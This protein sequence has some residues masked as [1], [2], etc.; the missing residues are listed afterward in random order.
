MG[1]R[2]KSVSA[3]QHGRPYVESRRPP[4][5][6]DYLPKTPMPPAHYHQFRATREVS[7]RA[8]CSRKRRNLQESDLVV[9]ETAKGPTYLQNTNRD[10]P[11]VSSLARS[12]RVTHAQEG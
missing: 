4:R 2:S 6:R 1:C 11:G 7:L 9:Q 10:F 3:F 12:V 8:V 5:F